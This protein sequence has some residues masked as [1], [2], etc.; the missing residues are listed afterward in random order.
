MKTRL[1]QAYNRQMLRFRERFRQK[2]QNEEQTP[3]IRAYSNIFNI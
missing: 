1:D 2:P 3:S